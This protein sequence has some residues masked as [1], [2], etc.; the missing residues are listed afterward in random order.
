MDGLSAFPLPIRMIRFA[1]TGEPLLHPQIARMV[2]YAKENTAAENVNLVTNA[3][4][5][6]PQLSLELIDAGLDV[7]RISVQGLTAARYREISGVDLDFERFV[8]QIRF[9]YAHRGAT[10]VHIKII[11]CALREPEEEAQ[12]Y[13]LFGGICDTI[14]VEHMTPTVKDIDYDALSGPQGPSLTQN[15]CAL[16]KTKICSLPFYMLQLNPDGNLMPCCHTQVPLVLGNVKTES[17]L[18]IWNGKKLNRF[19]ADMLRGADRCGEVCEGCTLYRYGLFPEDVL[20]D[21]AG[22]LIPV[23]ERKAAET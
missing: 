8:E 18:Q 3:A 4:L 7:L 10:R 20:D 15:G 19:R 5:L 21:F 23:Y 2:R 17:P 22:K 13:D 12:F 1:G 6:R 16:P 9:F 11:D 14:A